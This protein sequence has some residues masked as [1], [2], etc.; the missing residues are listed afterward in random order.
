MSGLD[1]YVSNKESWLSADCHAYETDYL[2]IL[3][4]QSQDAALIGIG[5]SPSQAWSR[6]VNTP[7]QAEDAISWARNAGWVKISTPEYEDWLS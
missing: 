4:G 3:T 5:P 1:D 7:I 2:V 6:L